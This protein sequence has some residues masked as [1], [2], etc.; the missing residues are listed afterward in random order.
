MK[1]AVKQIPLL[2][3]KDETSSPS[4]A[5]GEIK[6]PAD[7][8]VEASISRR[9]E[10]GRPTAAA[11]EQARH[12][13][14]SV[15]S[16]LRDTIKTVW[17]QSALKLFGFLTLL[18]A[19]PLSPDETAIIEEAISINVDLIA[20]DALESARRMTRWASVALAVV[21]L[22]VKVLSI[23]RRRKTAQTVSE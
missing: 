11:Q 3:P 1:L 7:G 22:V 14:Q 19:S 8:P 13:R 2:P 5:G 9:R 12:A 4:A 17:K 23:F 16:D 18:G 15:F 20:D 10:R 21:I 6:L